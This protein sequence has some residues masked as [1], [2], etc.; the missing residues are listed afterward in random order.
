MVVK[1]L[2]GIFLLFIAISVI[3][4]RRLKKEVKNGTILSTVDSTPFSLRD[5]RRY[6]QYR[7]ETMNFKESNPFHPKAIKEIYKSSKGYPRL[8]DTICDYALMAYKRK[9]RR[10]SKGRVRQIVKDI[11]THYAPKGQVTYIKQ[12]IKKPRPLGEEG[13]KKVKLQA[14]YSKNADGTI[15]ATIKVVDQGDFPTVNIFNSTSENPSDEAW[16]IGQGTES[17]ISNTLFNPDEAKQWVST[18]INSLKR[19]LD[20]WRNIVVPEPEEL[21]V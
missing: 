9:P 12:A 17:T 7:L 14:T 18:Q 20:A 8:I 4:V 3:L 13:G 15:E 21:E 1:L 10:I 11:E 6:I 19:K 2:L 16:N 5:T